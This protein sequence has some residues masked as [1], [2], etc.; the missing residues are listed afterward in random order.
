MERDG[1]PQRRR[2]GRE[3]EGME[4]PSWREGG[5]SETGPT[6]AGVVW[7]VRGTGVKGVHEPSDKPNAV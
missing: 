2:K 6:P 1:P 7:G 3:E 4:R 5:R